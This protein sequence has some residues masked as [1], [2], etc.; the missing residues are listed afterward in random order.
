MPKKDK[1]KAQPDGAAEIK[2]LRKENKRLR[3]ALA[4]IAKLAR[5]FEHDRDEEDEYRELLHDVDDQIDAGSERSRVVIE[6][7]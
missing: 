7:R 4:E 6:K 2:E 1:K 5:G 3:K